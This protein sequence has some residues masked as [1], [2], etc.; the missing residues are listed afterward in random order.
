[1]HNQTFAFESDF[2]DTLRCIPMAVRLKLDEARIK[3][4]LRQWS[5]LS[6]QARRALLDQPCRTP[7][8]IVAYQV[9]LGRHVAEQSDSQLR[10]LP[11]DQAIPLPPVDAPPEQVVAFAASKAVAP[12]AL[13]AWGNLSDLQRFALVKLSRDNHDNVNFVPALAEFGLLSPAAAPG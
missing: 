4:T 5:Q 12:I 8:E 10:I 11:D 9:E 7:A 1:M 6:T 3:L 2:V 13:E